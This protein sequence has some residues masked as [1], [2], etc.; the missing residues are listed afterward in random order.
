[1][2]LGF[3]VQRKLGILDRIDQTPMMRD[4]RGEFGCSLTD[5]GFVQSALRPNRPCCDT[6]SRKQL[7]S[8]LSAHH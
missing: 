6:L 1:M 5:L 7:N 3:F 8:M 4:E 2:G